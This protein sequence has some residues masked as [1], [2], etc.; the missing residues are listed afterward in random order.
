MRLWNFS[1]LVDWAEKQRIMCTQST[2]EQVTKSTNAQ[3]GQIAYPALTLMCTLS[4]WQMNLNSVTFKSCQRSMAMLAHCV[5]TVIKKG[6]SNERK[7]QL[8]TKPQHKSRMDG[9]MDGWMDGSLDGWTKS[10]SSND[11]YM[12]PLTMCREQT[13]FYPCWAGEQIAAF[14]TIW[15]I[16]LT[17]AFGGV[18][19]IFP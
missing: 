14:W 9:A 3:T 5:K 8:Q 11:R 4:K 7:R 1:L 16:W 15:R 12:Y 18:S 19:G 10:S 2:A 13:W 6:H 17:S